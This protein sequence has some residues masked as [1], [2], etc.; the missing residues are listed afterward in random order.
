MRRELDV[1]LPPGFPRR[2]PVNALAFAQEVSVLILSEGDIEKRAWERLKNKEKIP[3]PKY[4][5]MI[6]ALYGQYIKPNTVFTA[7]TKS[8][9]EIKETLKF[10][11]INLNI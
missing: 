10:V 11:G 3:P 9:K 4:M 1:T 8:L 7:S 2:S 5:K 6:N